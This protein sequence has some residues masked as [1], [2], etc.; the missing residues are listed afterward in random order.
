MCFVKQHIILF[1]AAAAFS[2]GG[3]RSGNVASSSGEESAHRQLIEML[4]PA[5]L[6][7]CRPGE[8]VVFSVQTVRDG[9]DS[10]AIYVAGRRTVLHDRELEY[11]LP[12]DVPLGRFAW[13][14]TAYAAGDS[15]VRYADLMLLARTLP[16]RYGYRVVNSYPHNTNSY[17]QGLL[18]HDGFLYEGTGI[19]GRS[20]LM[21]IDLATG[22]DVKRHNLEARYFGEGLALAGG[23][24]YQLTWQNG[25][26]F[27]Y[28]LNTFRQ[29]QKFSYSGEGWGLASDGK[30]LYMSD[31]TDRIYTVDPAD[32][33]R[34][35]Y[36]QACTNTGSVNRLNELEWIED[37]IWANVYGSWQIVRI[38]PATGRI[39]GVV[40][41][42]G[43]LPGESITDATDVLNGIAYDAG[44]RKIYV[45]GKNWSLLFEIEVVEKR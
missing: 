36:I 5:P 28:D 10:V 37:E 40:D 6:T 44:S 45:T 2:C 3:S 23:K 4:S 25:Q 33:T 14:A 21:K 17:T 43:I 42:E 7:K 9:V 38:D 41:L 32:F 11:D 8:R 22:R 29:L 27:V 18:W 39:N 24:L 12:P 15:S 26:A 31:G 34:K 19:E 35:G 30:M 13:H 20:A 16:V 1:I